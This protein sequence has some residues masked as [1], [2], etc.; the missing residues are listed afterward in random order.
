MFLQLSNYIRD[1]GKMQDILVLF[2]NR[3]VKRRSKKAMLKEYLE[4]KSKI[5][6]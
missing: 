3:K 6:P 1:G 2:E 5:F 4:V